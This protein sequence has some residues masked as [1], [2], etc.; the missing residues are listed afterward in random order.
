MPVGGPSGRH[1]GLIQAF[2]VAATGISF[3]SAV[4]LLALAPAPVLAQQG[5]S[6]PPLKNAGPYAIGFQ[7]VQ[8][9]LAVGSAQFAF[10]VVD[11]ATG[12]PVPGARVLLRT[13]HADSGDEALVNALNSPVAPARYQARVSLDSPGAWLVSVEVDSSLGKIALEIGS[14]EV[15]AP[16]RFSAGSIVFAG[17]FG[18]LLLGGLYLW[19]S[20][21]KMRR[22]R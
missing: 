12:S 19:W 1:I 3:V 22:Q 16:S 21:R 14:L 9:D 11:G 13:R 8:A 10:I 2:G 15:P 20:T 7:V 17:V 4:L 6:E 5:G 18:V